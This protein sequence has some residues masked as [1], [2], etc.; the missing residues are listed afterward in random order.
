MKEHRKMVTPARLS[1]RFAYTLSRTVSI[2]YKNSMMGWVMN[3][4]FEAIHESS[5][6][7]DEEN[8]LI[9]NL[10]C[11]SDHSDPWFRLFY[12]FSKREA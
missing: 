3:Y 7:F 8:G 1:S 9:G 11:Q 10:M 2:V 4:S 12:A 5:G 6:E